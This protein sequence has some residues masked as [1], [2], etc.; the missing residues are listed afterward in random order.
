MFRK[1]VW[2]GQRSG[3]PPSFLNTTN[4]KF[5][6]HVIGQPICV[7]IIRPQ[8]VSFMQVCRELVC[9]CVHR[10]VFSILNLFMKVLDSHIFH[11]MVHASNGK[12]SWRPEGGFLCQEYFL[13][14]SFII[15]IV[16]HSFHKLFVKLQ[17]WKT[18][19]PLYLVPANSSG[20]TVYHN[21]F[22]HKTGSHSE[23][24]HNRA[25]KCSLA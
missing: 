3:C 15:S 13:Y 5:F 22:S 16:L 17:K 9:L 8:N 1:K 14:F 6:C 11:Q 12:K 10:G 24:R 25:T 2:R 19:T 4:G 23:M 21:T 18:P 7:T 20:R